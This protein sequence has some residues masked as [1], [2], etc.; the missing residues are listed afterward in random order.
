[1]TVTFQGVAPG[2]RLP[3]GSRVRTVWLLN[4]YG[5]ILSGINPFGN[6][7]DEVNDSA[8]I[9]IDA[10]ASRGIGFVINVPPAIAPGDLGVVL[11]LKLA[12]AGNGFLASELA[13][14]LDKMASRLTLSR[15]GPIPAGESSAAAL[16]ARTSQTEQANTSAKDAL[17]SGVLTNAADSIGQGAQN[18]VTFI[19]WGG[20]ILLVVLGFW[21]WR[22]YGPRS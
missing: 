21:A 18:L 15:L 4:T 13:S 19:K 10:V 12:A 5:E 20:I 22:T 3:A 8:K 17:P 7:T 2:E 1:M 14:G 9:I 16:A 11:D 6:S